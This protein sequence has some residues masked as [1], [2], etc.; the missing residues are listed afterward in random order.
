MTYEQLIIECK[1]CNKCNL[2][3]DATQ[4]V[5]GDGNPKADIMFIG[6]GPGANEDKE[7]I[8]FCGAAGKFLDE[9]LGSIG[10]QRNDVYITN[11]IRCRPPGNR[12][13]QDDEIKACKSWTNGLIKIIKPKVFVLLGR[14]SMAKFFPKF[15]ISQVHGKAYKKWDR[16]FVIMYHP[17]VALYNGSFRET[18]INDMKVLRNILDG[19]DSVVEVL[20]EPESEIKKLLNKKR[21]TR[22][23]QTKRQI[24][25][26]L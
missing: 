13:P 17:A 4:V 24:G 18:L 26:G 15:K 22:Q 9:M 5:P 1:K 3:A 21:A 14:F 2:R 7:G 19:D 20:E 16:V 6:E 23:A 12:D 25:F 8:P 10:I 11:M